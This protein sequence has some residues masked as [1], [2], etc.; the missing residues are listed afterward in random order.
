MLPPMVRMLAFIPLATPVCS[1]GTA[2]TT[3]ADIAEKRP[4]R[5]RR[6]GCRWRR[7]ISH[8]CECA[9]ANIAIATQPDEAA[10]DHQH[11]AA[12]ARRVSEPTE[13]A[14]H[15]QVVTPEGSSIRPERVM[16]ALNP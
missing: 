2:D 9:K 13:Q 12:E 5:T 3:L 1:A 15:E 7:R 6:R 4:A 10:R 11:L 14:G 16:L 8:C